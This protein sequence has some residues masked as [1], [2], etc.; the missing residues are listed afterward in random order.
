MC[1]FYKYNYLLAQ[2]LVDMNSHFSLRAKNNGAN[3]LK[4]VL[5]GGCHFICI[6]ISFYVILLNKYGAICL[7]PVSHLLRI[8]GSMFLKNVFRISVLGTDSMG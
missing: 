7:D 8:L 4:S 5:F 6:C 3:A 1:E 2:L